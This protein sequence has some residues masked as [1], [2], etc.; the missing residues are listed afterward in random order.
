M[1][2]RRYVAARCWRLFTRGVL[3]STFYACSNA[4]PLV[5]LGKHPVSG[6][7]SPLPVDSRPPAPQ[8]QVVSDRPHASCAWLDGEWV[9]QRNAWVWREGG[10]VQALPGCYYAPSTLTWQG[11]PGSSGVLYFIPGQWYHRETLERCSPAV[12]CMP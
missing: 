6:G 1:R 2:V 12:A 8:V 4:V 11:G 9:W 5:P 10:W 3:G 7:V